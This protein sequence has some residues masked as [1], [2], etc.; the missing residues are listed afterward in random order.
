ME[1]LKTFFKNEVVFTISLICAIISM[2]FVPPNIDYITY[3]NTS[4][5]I[6]LFCLMLVVSGL[7]SIG[8]FNRLSKGL[9]D[10]V[11]TTKGI[12]LILVNL[13]LI[14]SMFITNDVAL[15]TLVPLTLK[16]LKSCEVKTIIKVVTME[17]ISANLGSMITP[18]GNPQNIFIYENYGVSIGEFFKIM[19][20]LGLVSLVTINLILILSK[21]ES[22]KPSKANEIQSIDKK[23]LILYIAMFLICILTILKII[24][25]ITCLILSLILTF[26]I[27]PKI[28]FKVDYVLLLTFVS[29]FIFVGNIGNIPIIKEVISN[30]LYGNEVI[31]SVM[32]S[33]VISNVPTTLMLSSFTD[34]F[35]NLLIGVNLGGLG[36]LIGSLAS[37]ISFKIFTK[38]YPKNGKTYL[39]I[40]TIYNFSI[41][42]L[43]LL[44]YYVFL[45]NWI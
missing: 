40:F 1:K 11:S 22:I 43:L 18:I 30:I 44:V 23:K 28:L 31:I 15:I 7:N 13:C 33:Q 37:L 9:L 6:M 4:V 10:K 38:D 8:V 32:L 25:H 34:N 16:I 3:I 17:T 21:S 42:I 45:I 39:K 2:I 35:K 12:S 19:L 27:N 26:I 41:L 36:T 24:N 29:F 14:L 5:L 20:P